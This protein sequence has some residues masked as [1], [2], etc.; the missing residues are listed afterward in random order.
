VRALDVVK[1]FLAE[2]RVLPMSLML[3]TVLLGGFFAK[4]PQIDWSVMGLVLLNAFCFLYVAHLND[5][6]W[7]LKKG[8]YEEGRKLHAV[9]LK[10]GYYLPRWGFGYEVPNAPILPRSYYAIGMLAFS[11]LGLLV[12]FYLSNLLGWQYGA[13]AMVGLLLALTYSAGIDKVPALGDTWWEIGVL[14]A[15][16]CGYYSQALRIDEFVLTTA[17][18]LFISLVGVKALDSLPDTLVDHRNNKV[19]LTVFL[20]RRGL[21]LR[22]IRHVCYAPLY[23]AFA[24]LFFGLP[25]S[26]RLGALAC[27]AA[28]AVQQYALRN[29]VAG[30]HSIVVAGF[31]ILAF[32]VVALLVIAGLLSLPSF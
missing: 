13:L 10:E 9:R 15:L 3:L 27:V 14:F 11:A 30:R 19:T 7:D 21:S 22:A 18:P 32:V 8:E 2:V 24:I 1:G 29:D 23:V 4:G 28:F 16:F 5:T 20:Y 17:V 6:F 12:M 25:P 31:T 26:M